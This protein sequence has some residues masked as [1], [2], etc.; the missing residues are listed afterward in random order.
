MKEK[1]K[2]SI[3]NSP[4]LLP[5]IM[6]IGGVFR[7]YN[8]FSRYSFS[9]ESIRDAIVAYI[10]AQQIQFPLTGPFSSVGP[11]TFGPWYWYH[12]IISRIF[13]P[14]M[15]SPWVLLGI[16]S[17]ATIYIYYKI[18]VLLEDRELGLILALFVA[19]SPVQIVSAFGLNNPNLIHFYVALSFY[20]F[21]RH[22]IKRNNSIFW[23]F[24]FGIALGIGANIHYQMF[25]LFIL[26]IIVFFNTKKKLIFA[27][28]IITGI[29][30]TFLPL[31]FFDLNNH[32]FTLRNFISYAVLGKDK[33]IIS[34]RWLFY[35]R[36]FWPAL[37]SNVFGTPNVI[38][39]LLILFTLIS[40]SYLTIKKKLSKAYYLILIGFFFDFVYLRYYGGPKFFG[41]LYFLHPYIFVLPVSS[42]YIFA[43]QQR[44][45]VLI[46]FFALVVL[47]GF[48]IYADILQV[49]PDP[50]NMKSKRSVQK[51][52]KK[53][54]GNISLFWC[55]K[56]TSSL[57]SMMGIFFLLYNNKRLGN[58]IK[59]YLGSGKCSLNGI[60]QRIVIMPIEG[61]PFLDV[62]SLTNKELN[63]AGVSQMDIQERY[64]V[65]AR[66]W[67]KEQP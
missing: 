39:I 8:A 20:L 18:G 2:S 36:D 41:Y 22:I 67:F 28:G 65:Y 50:S 56:D 13:L 25:A 43:K 23:N 51:L 53:Y 57:S 27:V 40:L 61:T 4:Y 45:R 30:I 1:E 9:E 59:L 6:L 63:R 58:D 35:I 66:W 52:E 16:F 37:F 7:F 54:A 10:G 11:F 60:G 12:L 48:S 49:Q 5:V 64:N 14:T 38:S 34:Y 33:Q 15:F 29:T 47:S 32:W 62:S 3:L 55:K 42:I 17:T 44:Y 26:P 19:L 24:F 21:L 31:I 46:I